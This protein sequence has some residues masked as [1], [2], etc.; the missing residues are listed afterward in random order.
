FISQLCGSLLA[1]MSRSGVTSAA[2]TGN[3]ALSANIDTPANAR[4][5]VLRF[6]MEFLPQFF[7]IAKSNQGIVAPCARAASGDHAAATPPSSVMT[8]RRACAL[9]G[10]LQCFT[11]KRCAARLLLHVAPHG[12]LGGPA[13]IDVAGIVHAH[14]FRRASLDRRLRNEGGDFAV[15]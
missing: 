5:V 12:H 1:L 2:T 15:L 8:L 10:P 6:L 3:A 7:L 11:G 14:A 4:L 13:G 9:R